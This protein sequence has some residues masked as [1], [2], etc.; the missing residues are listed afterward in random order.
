MDWYKKTLFSNPAKLFRYFSEP[1]SCKRVWFLYVLFRDEYPHLLPFHSVSACSVSAHH[2][3]LD[4]SAGHKYD[5]IVNGKKMSKKHQN[6]PK[7][8]AMGL[9][10]EGNLQSY[11]LSKTWNRVSYIHA[12][13]LRSFRLSKVIHK[14]L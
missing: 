14:T 6:T 4:L 11:L 2:N 13:A 5:V 1:A 7:T 3:V 8:E 12:S 10:Q 9:F